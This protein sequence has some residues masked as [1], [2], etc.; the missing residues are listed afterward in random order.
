MRIC[1][2]PYARW[3]CGAPVR[4]EPSQTASVVRELPN[5]RAGGRGACDAVRFEAV[6]LTDIRTY[7]HADGGEPSMV[8]A[9]WAWGE[10]QD[11]VRGESSREARGSETRGHGR[12][13]QNGRNSQRSRCRG[14]S[15]RGSGERSNER[16]ARGGSAGGLRGGTG[17]GAAYRRTCSDDKGPGA[18]GG[19]GPASPVSPG[20]SRSPE[21]SR[22]VPAPLAVSPRRGRST[23]A[24][25]HSMEGCSPGHRCARIGVR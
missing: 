4:A 11:A 7:G 13:S 18:V 19:R 2:R 23:P 14:R 21:P 9:A 12:N 3:A 16:G 17:N 24:R 22:S 25:G 6:G 8:R 20:T 15:G 1:A 5:R 10:A